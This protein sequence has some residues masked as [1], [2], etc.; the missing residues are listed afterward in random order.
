MTRTQII[1]LVRAKM[2]EIHPFAQGDTIVDPQIDAQL[3]S[4]AVKL[5]EGLPSVLAFP[6]SA[7]VGDLSVTNHISE[8]SL[9]IECPD[10][11]IRLHRLKLTGWTRPVIEL[12]PDG[13]RLLYEQD[14]E[15]IRATVRRPKAALYNMGGVDY[16][17]C[18][19]APEIPDPVPPGTVY[20]NEFVYVQKPDAAE[21]L[22][23]ALM[24]MLAWKVAGEIYA[25]ARQKEDA[26][27][28]YER[29]NLIISDKLKYGH[30]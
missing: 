30:R 11:F 7:T 2:D 19:P 14:Y 17:S 4:A 28:C 23:V 1:D 24:D 16:I 22:N 21:D 20:I 6:V 10:D 5:M 25:I 3:D 18:Y 12:I 26:L 15:M 29:L 13:S 27:M 8:Y 9:D